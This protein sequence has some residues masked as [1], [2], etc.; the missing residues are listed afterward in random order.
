MMNAVRQ[1]FDRAKQADFAAHFYHCFLASSAAVRKKFERTDFQRQRELLIHAVYSM[2]DYA[3]GRSMGRL[4]IERLARLHDPDHLDIPDA[5]YELWLQAF[6]HALRRADPLFDE[7]LADAWR[8][9]LRPAID[10]MIET[11]RSAFTK[12]RYR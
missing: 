11:H 6:I 2:L 10:L 12:A 8:K 5:M 9:A 1:S 3:S 7:T 4:A